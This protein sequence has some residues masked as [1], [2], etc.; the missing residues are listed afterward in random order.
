MVRA[1]FSAE[2]GLL[3]LCELLLGRRLEQHPTRWQA[4]FHPDV[5]RLGVWERFGV[6]PEL[7]AERQGPPLV[8]PPR[9]GRRLLV[10][11][12]VALAA[13]AGLLVASGRRV[14]RRAGLVL[15]ALVLGVLA[16]VVDALG[17]YWRIVYLHGNEV[18]LV[19]LP[20]DFALVFLAGRRLR[21]YLDAR[22]ALLGGCVLL[23]W[24][25]VLVQPLGPAIVVAGL[26]LACVRAA[27]S[28]GAAWPTWLSARRPA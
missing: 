18:A 1:G 23:V 25:G 13:L 28:E 21:V 14:P 20:T 24:A 11:V 26:P 17:F 15:V 9:A 16:L 5:L 10:W 3:A 22:L 19:L 7:V 6:K 12:A 8:G 2:P 27:L 4:M